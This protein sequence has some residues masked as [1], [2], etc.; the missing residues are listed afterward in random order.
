MN[1]IVAVYVKGLSFFHISITVSSPFLFFSFSFV[2]VL[3]LK[4]KRK[5]QTSSHSSLSSSSSSASSCCSSSRRALPLDED[6]AEENTEVID[7]AHE[8]GA[9]TEPAVQDRLSLSLFLFS[10]LPFPRAKPAPF[11]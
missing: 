6:E 4:M 9:V 1:A 7:A 2:L 10:V 8:L 11:S 5:R 3:L